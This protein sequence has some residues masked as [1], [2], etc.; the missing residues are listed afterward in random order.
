M[1]MIEAAEMIVIHPDM[2]P[3][4]KMK[5]LV[6]VNFNQVLAVILVF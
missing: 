3:S 4:V 5:I 2:S 1:E 6:Q